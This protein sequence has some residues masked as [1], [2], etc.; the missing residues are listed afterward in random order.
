LLALLI[1]TP[2]SAQVLAPGQPAVELD[3]AVDASGKPFKLAAFRGRWL[4]VTIGASWCGPCKDELVAWNKLAA[5]F[6][7][8]VVFVSLAIDNEIADGKAFH[9]R[10]GVPSLV[11]AYM[12][13]E[14]SKVV[15]RYGAATMPATFVIGPDGIVRHVH[16]GFEQ[17]L[18]AQESQKLKTALV[19][20]LPKPK[21]KPVPAPLPPPQSPAPA[22]TPA[23]FAIPPLVLPDGP[24]AELWADHFHS[25]AF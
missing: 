16:P 8:R 2:A 13:E 10:L 15:D 3:I 14:H 4:V 19:G 21:P 17:K 9:K 22:P 20:L 5:E 11:R 12:P 24:H 7:G 23:V 25:I 1:A 18:A 6:A